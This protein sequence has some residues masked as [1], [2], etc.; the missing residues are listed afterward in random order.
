MGIGIGIF[1]KQPGDTLDFDV[2]YGS[3]FFA[4][5]GDDDAIGSSADVDV[6]IVE[7]NLGDADDLVLGEGIRPEFDLIDDHTVKVWVSGGKTG[8]RY[9]VT[10][11]A[12]TTGLRIKEADVTVLVKEQ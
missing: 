8:R 11:T 6:E 10:V 2:D 7:G 4:D 12:T 3:E 9:K 1:E 5:Y